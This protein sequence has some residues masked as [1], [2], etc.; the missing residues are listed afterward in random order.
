MI[1]LQDSR[2]Q[3]PWIFL[4]YDG[5]RGQKTVKLDAGDYGV[6]EVPKLISIERKKTTGEIAINLGSKYSRFVKEMERLQQYRFRYVLCEFSLERLLKFPN[7]SGIPKYRWSRL[8]ITGRYL[9]SKINQL[10]ETYSVE[11]IFCE[12]RE[13][14]R[15]KAME[16]LLAAK[17]V[18]DREHN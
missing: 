9:V 7:E 5:C 14:A 2:E 10:S 12:N 8:R 11:F 6:Q 15:N 3:E 4:N 17:S 1:I 16:L 18:Y 13:E